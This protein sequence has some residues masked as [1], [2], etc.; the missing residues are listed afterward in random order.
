[1]L[2]LENPS[3]APT[4]VRIGTMTTS[5]KAWKKLEGTFSLNGLP[6]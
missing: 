2:K 4:F 5:I 1:M 3:L 6:Y